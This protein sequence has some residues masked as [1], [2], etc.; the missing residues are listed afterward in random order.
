MLSALG[1]VCHLPGALLGRGAE[2]FLTLNKSFA[3]RGL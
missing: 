2:H 1:D 3:G